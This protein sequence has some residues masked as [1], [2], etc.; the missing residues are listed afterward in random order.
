MWSYHRWLCH[1]ALCHSLPPAAPQDAPNKEATAVTEL[2]SAEDGRC[3]ALIA[4]EDELAAAGP[5]A[6][7]GSAAARIWPRQ[8]L[9]EVSA[10][11]RRLLPP[12]VCLLAPPCTR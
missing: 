9:A 10:L 11:Q 1:A 6:L 4:A 5:A 8:M 7:Q 3:R 2:L 12:T